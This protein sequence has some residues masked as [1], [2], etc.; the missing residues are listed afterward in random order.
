MGGGVRGEKCRGPLCPLRPLFVHFGATLEDDDE[1]EDDRAATPLLV[2][3]RSRRSSGL[4]SPL[5]M[6]R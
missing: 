4:N 1:Y 6:G 2:P 5:E 3:A